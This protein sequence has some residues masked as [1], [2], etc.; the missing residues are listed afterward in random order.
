MDQQI[1]VG[2]QAVQVESA[3]EADSLAN[4]LDEH[5]VA[6]FAQENT[7]VN[8][9]I[10]LGDMEAYEKVSLLVKTWRMYA[11]RQLELDLEGLPVYVKED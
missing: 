3:D 7:E 4:Y 10:V 5:G 8:I 1:S 6:A 11:A 2:Y 9:P